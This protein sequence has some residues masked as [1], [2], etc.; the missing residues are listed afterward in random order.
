M[1]FKETG[2]L[3]VLGDV[4][5]SE[6]K[7]V[8][9]P[10]DGFDLDLRMSDTTVAIHYGKSPANWD[11]AGQGMYGNVYQNNNCKVGTVELSGRALDKMGNP[12]RVR[13]HVVKDGKYPQ[14]LIEGE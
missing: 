5:F 7:I 6:K 13:L 10:N 14:L 12:K 4:S 3:K 1:D 8:L 11:E 9:N 2:F